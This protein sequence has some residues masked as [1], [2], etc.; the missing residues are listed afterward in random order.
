MA[1]L[2]SGYIDTGTTQDH[3]GSLT[4]KVRAISPY[5]PCPVSAVFWGGRSV[6]L[7]LRRTG[8]VIDCGDFESADTVELWAYDIFSSGYG[9]AILLDTVA[10]ACPQPYLE[11]DVIATVTGLKLVSTF[12][13]NDKIRYRLWN[14]ATVTWHLDVGGFVM[15]YT[16][17]VAGELLVTPYLRTGP[18]RL[19]N[20]FATPPLPNTLADG[21]VVENPIW[22]GDSDPTASDTIAISMYTTGGG[23]FSTFE[24]AWHSYPPM[25]YEADVRVEDAAGTTPGNDVIVVGNGATVSTIV[26]PNTD[27]IVH[28]RWAGVDHIPVSGEGSVEA[29]LDG[30]W[31][32]AGVNPFEEDL[33]VP[34]RQ[35]KPKAPGSAPQSWNIGTYQIVSPQSILL[36]GV[37]FSGTGA[38]VLS[39]SENR[40]WAVSGACVV[41]RALS[42]SWR[43][44]NTPISPDYQAA[45]QFRATKFDAYAS[46]AADDRWGFGLYAYLDV[47]LTAPAT[48]DVTMEL[49]WVCA[50]PSPTTTTRT[51]TVPVT[52]GSN[53]YRVDL[54]FP[55]EPSH[56]FYGERVDTIKFYGMQNGTYHLTDI[57]LVGD[58]D[59]YVKIS[60]RLFSIFAEDGIDVS[61]D[62]SF[63]VAHWGG[64]LGGVKDDES[65]RFSFGGAPDT[66][67][68][69]AIR[70]TSTIQ[71]ALVEWD[72]MEGMDVAYTGGTIAVDLT[73]GT[74]IW[75]NVVTYPASW[76]HQ[77][78]G[79][80]ANQNTSKPI[81]ASVYCAG[82]DLC[83]V[84]AGKI[85]IP[86]RQV[87]GMI[88][89]AQCYDNSTGFRPSAG[90]TVTAKRSETGAESPSDTVLNT[91]TTDASGFVSI[92]IPAGTV[93]VDEDDFYAYLEGA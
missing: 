29:S 14:D 85:V 5:D 74:N 48:G 75:G 66:L 53:T 52:S 4:V 28:W 20:P 2:P 18:F 10:G 15:D 81:A 51:Y 30:D 89:E 77:V 31:S 54:L 63:S 91:G 23:G 7:E 45:D 32:V 80:R 21:F 36:S 46:G 88:L 25:K 35:I 19:V 27:A 11:V 44:W 12:D 84:D 87:I 58:Q 41:T 67:E 49:T 90:S 71:A 79:E 47:T 42:E 70:M 62:G 72:L 78:M 38:V 40:D 92:A 37:S 76:L 50:G 73:D 16:G 1:A 61:M 68:G 60:K 56:P 64:N 24:P 93:G 39:A 8:S 34:V 65:G 55:N 59:A 43:D 17:P 9:G 33:S 13:A 82:A 86:F 22:N 3:D 6:T 26:N 83:P 57:A 69:G